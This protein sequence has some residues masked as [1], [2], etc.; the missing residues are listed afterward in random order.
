MIKLNDYEKQLKD[1]FL[2]LKLEAGSHSPSMETLKSSI[3]EIEVKIDACFLSNPYATDLF[4]KHLHRDLILTNNLRRF[5]EF[6]PS[7]NQVIAAKIGSAI[8][9]DPKSIF[10]GNGAIEIIQAVIQKMVKRKMVVVLP[11]FSSFY[12]F[13][14]S[15]LEIVYYI[16]DKADNFKLDLSKLKDFI[17]IE[18]PDSL[19]IVN[20]NNPTGG[21]LHQN[22]LIEFI[23]AHKNLTNI[24]VDESFIH[25]AYE[26]SEM[27]NI[28]IQSNVNEYPNLIVIKSMSK[29]FGIA[30]IR[31]GYA[32]ME[33]SR[34]KELIKH[35]Y[36]WNSNGLSEYFYSKY[37]DSLFREDYEIVRKNYIRETKN[38]FDNLKNIPNIRTY[39]SMA[40]F[41]LIELI[42]GTKAEDFVFKLLL[43][44]GVYT[45]VGNDK[46]GLNGEFIRIAA[47]SLD[48]NKTVIESIRLLF[49]LSPL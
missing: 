47:R 17:R 13:A 41:L 49:G 35:G 22:E 15:N 40:N 16:L 7:Q 30:G 24:I 46:K 12:E 29:D 8:S 37:S 27:N 21:Y 38:F 3:P 10:V 26:D 31:A 1:R 2:K 39:P 43:D 45:R 48:E 28:S 11:T 9:L 36:L 5:L 19:V 23:D 20:P 25:F 14:E 4:I 6:Y 34:V 44:Y 33:P 18:K 42:D 32:I